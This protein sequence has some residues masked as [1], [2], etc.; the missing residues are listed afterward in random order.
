MESTHEHL[1]S[2]GDFQQ[3]IHARVIAC[4]PAV[5]IWTGCYVISNKE[6]PHCLNQIFLCIDHRFGQAFTRV[7][8]PSQLAET[9]IKAV[10]SLLEITLN[11]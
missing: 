3:R 5:P 9:M 8:P 7:S 10:Y 4:L 2:L 11:N 6:Y 1:L